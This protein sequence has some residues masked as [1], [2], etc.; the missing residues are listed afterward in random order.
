MISPN[1]KQVRY[2]NSGMFLQWT[3]I[4]QEKDGLLLKM[5]LQ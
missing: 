4:A 5:E 1:W 2:I 3:V